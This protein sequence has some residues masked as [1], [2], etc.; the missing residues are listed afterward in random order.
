VQTGVSSESWEAER[1][2]QPAE[3]VG[4][5]KLLIVKMIYRQSYGSHEILL[6][7]KRVKRLQEGG[8][9]LGLQ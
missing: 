3:V 7:W 4:E 2:L 1:L 8:E 5:T 9:L 6:L